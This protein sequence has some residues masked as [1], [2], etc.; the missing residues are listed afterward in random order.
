MYRCWRHSHARLCYLGR[1]EKLKLHESMVSILSMRS[2]FKCVFSVHELYL[3]GKIIAL[4]K[5]TKFI[6]PCANTFHTWNQPLGFLLPSRAKLLSQPSSF[7]KWVK[8]QAFLFQFTLERMRW[9]EDNTMLTSVRRSSIFKSIFI[10]FFTS[11]LQLKIAF[12]LIPNIYSNFFTS[13]SFRNETMI[14]T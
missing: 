14:T 11:F 10:H 9:S 12:F 5:I 8:E 13:R 1:K 4:E 7:S 2:S 3:Y 6:V